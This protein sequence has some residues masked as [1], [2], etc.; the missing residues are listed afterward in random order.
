MKITNR[1]RY[2]ARAF[3]RN[4]YEL[5][6]A[7]IDAMIEQELKDIDVDA[8]HEEQMEHEREREKERAGT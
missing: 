8:A 1:E 2:L 4:S 5:D 7:E 6:E 3:I